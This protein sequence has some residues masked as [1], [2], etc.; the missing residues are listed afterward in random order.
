MEKKLSK[1]E[2]LNSKNALIYKK[3]NKV[4]TAAYAGVL[5]AII[6]LVFDYVY[7]NDIMNFVLD[8]LL[9]VFSLIFVIVMSRAK[10]KQLSKYVLNSK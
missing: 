8:G 10:Q 3:A 5:L 1:E 2:F 9:F 6:S 7:K 4:L